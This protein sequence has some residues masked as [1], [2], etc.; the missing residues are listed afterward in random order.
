GED[1]EGRGGG[2][3]ALDALCLFLPGGWYR[4]ADRHDRGDRADAAAQASRQTPERRR[5]NCAHQGDRHRHRQGPAG[6][7]TLESS[8]GND[9]TI[10]LGHYLT[11]A[12][13]LFTI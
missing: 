1:V 7:G 3:G 4:A 9:M 13:I 10:G 5:P 2:G 11:V 8:R 12:A 6:P